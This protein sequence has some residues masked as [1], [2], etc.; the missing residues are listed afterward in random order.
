MPAD[1]K[2]KEADVA[3]SISYNNQEKPC[4]KNKLLIRSSLPGGT[5]TVNT[6]S[7]NTTAF[8]KIKQKLTKLK[9]RNKPHN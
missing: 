1:S 5:P 2:V 6:N 9:G 8:K 4:Y 3:L 7:F